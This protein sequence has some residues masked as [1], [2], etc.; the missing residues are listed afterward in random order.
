LLYA[1]GIASHILMD[2]TTSFGT[3]MWTPL[4]SRRV[5]WDMI[6][7]VDLIFTAILLVPQ[8]LAWIYGD[9]ER[10]KVR[11]LGMWAIFTL[12]AVAGWGAA[13]AAGFPFHAWVIAV[14]SA[15]FAVVFFAPGV[16]GSN[17][18]G[19]GFKLTRAEW[20]RVGVCLAFAYV[21]A[22]GMAHHAAMS[23]V[24]HFA[25]ANHLVVERIGALP[26]APSLLSWAAGIRSVDGVYQSQF[27]LRNARGITFRYFPDSPPDPAVARAM[28]LPDV[29]AFW[30]FS[31]FPSIRTRQQD[32]FDVVD[33]GEN[34]YVNRRRGPQPFTYRVV[35][36][37]AGAIVEEGMTA[38]GIFLRRMGREV[39]PDEKSGTPGEAP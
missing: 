13:R 2:G 31:R 21:F 39:L 1:V 33:I 5:A 37:D 23:R 26:L 15:V 34:R 3:R 7:I 18:R 14:A 16:A 28:A 9:V 11:A 29:R 6:F 27:D 24:L 32:G 30:G 17:G 35:F 19:W 12:A 10:S 36:D 25:D 20:C 4:S 8:V 38:D 22:C